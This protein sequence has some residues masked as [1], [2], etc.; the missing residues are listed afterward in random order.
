MTPLRS[1]HRND[2]AGPYLRHAAE[3]LAPL[4]P[5][6]RLVVQTFQDQ[7][8]SRRGFGDIVF[9]P[10]QHKAFD[11]KRRAELRPMLALLDDSL[12]AER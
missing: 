1:G 8:T 2:D 5:P 7:K 6:K 4:L 11:D 10:E 12:E 3:D 9:V